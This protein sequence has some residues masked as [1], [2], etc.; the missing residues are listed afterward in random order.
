MPTT[1]I[2]GCPSSCGL[3]TACPCP[4]RGRAAVAKGALRAE[5]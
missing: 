2:T 5:G 1:L 4:D 3:E